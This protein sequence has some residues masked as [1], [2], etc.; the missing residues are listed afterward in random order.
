VELSGSAFATVNEG[1]KSWRWSLAFVYEASEVRDHC[2]AA[3]G[4]RLNTLQTRST[5]R[6]METNDSVNDPIRGAWF[7]VGD[8]DEGTWLA[9][10]NF[11]SVSTECVAARADETP[12]D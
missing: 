3:I 6:T 11:E 9:P 4:Q 10:L 12:S 5:Q 7:K 1:P 8:S 2:A